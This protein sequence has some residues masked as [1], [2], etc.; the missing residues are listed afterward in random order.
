[1]KRTELTLGETS[2]LDAAEKLARQLNVDVVLVLTDR[3]C[4]FRKIAQE[5]KKVRLV[6][7]SGSDDVQQSGNRG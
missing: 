2:L 5:L 4:D 7:A 6:V 1:M 3:P